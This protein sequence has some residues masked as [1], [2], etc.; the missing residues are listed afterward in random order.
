MKDKI[1]LSGMKFYGYHGVLEEE[2]RLGQRFEVDLELYLNLKPAGEADD[3]ALTVS[4]ADVFETVK[5]VVTGRSRK[6]LEAVAEDIG[7]QVL[8]QYEQVAGVK[9]L[10]KKPGAPINGDFRYMAVEIQ[11]GRK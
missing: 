5:Q 4:Y 11:R 2:Q 7:R 6:L 10:L 3:P 9:V 8:D 1:I